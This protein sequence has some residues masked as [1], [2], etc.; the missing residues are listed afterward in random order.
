M[1]KGKFKTLLLGLLLSLGNIVMAQSVEE[2]T[3]KNANTIKILKR[4]Y[5]FNKVEIRIEEDGYWYFYFKKGYQYGIAN[6]NGKIIVP[7]AYDLKYTYMPQREEGYSFVPCKDKWGNSVRDFLMYHKA[8]DRGFLV[9][10][11]IISTDGALVKELKEGRYTYLNGLLVGC[12]FSDLIY[13][14]CDDR[15]PYKGTAYISLDLKKATHFNNFIYTQTG[16]CLLEEVNEDFMIDEFGNIIFSRYVQNRYMF[17]NSKIKREHNRPNLDL[18]GTPQGLAELQKIV[19]VGALDDV[20]TKYKR[21]IHKNIKRIGAF[22]LKSNQEVVPCLFAEV[23]Y[24]QDG[25][26]WMVKR[27]T[28]APYE[29]YSPTST[30]DEISYAD[31]GE[32]LFESRCYQ[33]VLDYYIEKGTNSSWGKYMSALSLRNM[34]KD[35]KGVVMAYTIIKALNNDDPFYYENR[36]SYNFDL[37]VAY[38][39]LNVGSAL[40]AVYMEE[41]STYYENAVKEKMQFLRDIKEIT[42]LQTEYESA[43]DNYAKRKDE[44]RRAVLAEIEKR[45]IEER[46]RQTQILTTVLSVF[47][48]A[49]VNSTMSSSAKSSSTYISNTGVTPKAATSSSSSNNQKKVWPEWAQKSFRDAKEN[50]EEAVE[51]LRKAEIRLIKDETNVLLRQYVDQCRRHVKDWENKMKEYAAV[52]E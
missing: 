43:L 46:N 14:Y 9:S 15:L 27:K 24:N 44:S 28:V 49:V 36:D 26:D 19:S 41:D 29:S 10:N 1:K 51:E 6:Q 45:K 13:E 35:D 12:E 21:E 8:A 7:P 11:K 38:E 22:S 30:Y 2:L 33:N 39:R 3:Y 52:R 40:L 42:T 5:G 17:E 50:Y 37:N 16:E 31:V 20:D 47:A 25:D 32:A 4:A 34:A 23:F 48:V 18:M